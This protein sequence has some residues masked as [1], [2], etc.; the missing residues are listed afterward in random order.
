MQKVQIYV[1]ATRLDLFKDETIKLTQSLKNIN[2]VDKIFTEFTQTFAVPASST[3]NILFEHYYNFNIVEGF[4]AR[5]KQPA[6]IELNYIPFKT[7]LMRLDGVDLKDNKAYAYRITFFGETVNL[8]DILATNQIDSLTLDIYNTTYEPNTV[9]NGMSL[10]PLS[11]DSN[12]NYNNNL[13]VPLISHTNPI[14]YDSNS[15]VVSGTN[16]MYYNAGSGAG[17]FYSDLKY[18][19]RVETIVNAISTDYLVP[20]GLSF[21][22]DFF[23]TE[24]KPYSTLFLW[25]HRKSGS[26]GAGTAGSNQ[27]SLP[28]SSWARTSGTTL[29]TTG[30]SII[31][32]S[33]YQSPPSANISQ[34]DVRI[35]PTDSSKE[36]TL[37]I[38]TFGSEFYSSG[39]V[40]GDL[41]L[42]KND[43]NFIQP[44]SYTFVLN[45]TEEVVFDT[46]KLT[47]SG[48]FQI[49]NGLQYWNDVFNAASVSQPITIPLSVPFVINE[50][51]PEMKI[52]DFLTGIFK[53]FNLVAYYEDSKIVVK[54]YDD[55]FASLDTGL[56]EEQSSEWQDELR[57]WNEIGSTTSNE[58]SIDEFLDTGSVKVD[59]ALPYKQIN[60]LYEGTGTIL[61]K[62]YN[63][64]NN[65]GWGEIRYTLDGLV[66]DAPSDVYNV[67]IPFEHMQMER[68]N[69]LNLSASNTQTN[70]MY[71]ISVNENVQP[72]IGKPLLFYPIKQSQAFGSATSVSV[73]SALSTNV[74]KTDIIVPSNSV[75]LSPLVSV[76]NINFP[77]EINEWTLN[78]DF[79][80]SLFEG[81]Y[82][83]FISESFNLRRRFIKVKAYLPLNV[84]YNL[85]LNNVIEI[86]NERYK[87][88]SMST[89]FQTGETSFELINVL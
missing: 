10:D 12:G 84:L 19:L 60:F 16:N 24:N 39:P 9:L 32:S 35:V 36:Y 8:K 49:G 18:A 54:T 21:S 79:S 5:R 64:L 65:I 14:F 13:V 15:P 59:V 63:Q 4:D 58:Y 83:T 89:N 47:V 74:A 6:S 57:K 52:I 34:F 51:I 67:K 69:D 78:S 1:G 71:G 73:R 66:Y 68:L 20:A 37:I 70:V 43:F 17:V 27:L 85:K 30:T 61:A 86:N 23:N 76:E 40:T 48:D 45:S 26:V 82:K 77:N 50:Q 88:N 31:I 87:I 22:D 11:L 44:V 72:Y 28:V 56:W 53:M 80:N 2:K 75:S 33:Q 46:V 29:T 41:S 42:T 38:N 62:K 7:G 3:N 25:L 55:Y 81:Y